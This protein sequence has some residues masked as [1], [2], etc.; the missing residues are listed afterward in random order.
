MYRIVGYL[1]LLMC[2]AS[3]IASAETYEPPLLKLNKSIAHTLNRALRPKE[4]VSLEYRLQV[5]KSG[6]YR[7]AMDFKK[8][9]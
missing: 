6:L 2:V 9:G 5:Q 3:S 7:L 8:G 4:I 1:Y